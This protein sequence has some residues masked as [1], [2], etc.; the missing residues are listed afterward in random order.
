MFIFFTPPRAKQLSD[1]APQG[2]GEIFLFKRKRIYYFLVKGVKRSIG[3]GNS[4][5]ELPSED[6]SLRV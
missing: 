1:Y 4:V 3:I 2:K 6:I 5:V